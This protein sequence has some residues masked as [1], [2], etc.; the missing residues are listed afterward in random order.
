MGFA[1]LL[2]FARLV[3]FV[4]E[5]ATLIFHG[6]FTQC[7]IEHRRKK[8][9]NEDSTGK[10]SGAWYWIVYFPLVSVLQ[11]RTSSS[12]NQPS[13]YF[14][15]SMVWV[16][17]FLLLSFCVCVCMFCVY[18]FYIFLAC[19][20]SNPQ[21]WAGRVTVTGH[22]GAGTGCRNEFQNCGPLTNQ[23]LFL[24]GVCKFSQ[25]GRMTIMKINL[26]LFYPFCPVVFARS[27]TRSSR[28][29]P[30][31]MIC[32]CTSMTS[33]TKGLRFFEKKLRPCSLSRCIVDSKILVYVH[34]HTGKACLK[35]LKVR[36]SSARNFRL[37]RLTHIHAGASKPPQTKSL[38]Y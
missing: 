11:A 22:A 20:Y 12:S 28:A 17:V 33:K 7:H 2:F 21:W 31:V 6:Y 26:S 32:P 38:C 23:A 15:I 37:V 25:L 1:R 14:V 35:T 8:M 24:Y 19:F 5:F 36:A 27:R 30:F 10:R 34:I 16:C 29:H 4:R 18:S 3:V 13:A 9:G